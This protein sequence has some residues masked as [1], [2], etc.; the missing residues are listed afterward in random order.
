[1][2]GIGMGWGRNYI[3]LLSNSKEVAILE[4]QN[5]D[6]SIILKCTLRHGV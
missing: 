5:I 4:K 3:L 6:I 2:A 1:M